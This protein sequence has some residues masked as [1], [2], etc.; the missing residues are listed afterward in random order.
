M[1]G[2]AFQEVAVVRQF[3]DLC[4]EEYDDLDHLTYCPHT[5]F[6]DVKKEPWASLKATMF[7]LMEN[8]EAQVVAEQKSDFSQLAELA[9]EEMA[10]QERF[11]ELDDECSVIRAFMSSEKGVTGPPSSL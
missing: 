4:N 11:R 7:D 3:C 8:Q 5:W 10:L 2:E 1:V 9:G 6:P